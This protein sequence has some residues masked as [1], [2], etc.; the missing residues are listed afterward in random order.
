M[1]CSTSP[2][3]E[4]CR[5]G[6]STNSSTKVR[7]RVTAPN[8]GMRTTASSMSVAAQPGILGIRAFKIASRQPMAKLSARKHPPAA[9]GKLEV[10]AGCAEDRGEYNGAQKNGDSLPI[11]FFQHG[12]PKK[13]KLLL[14]TKGPQVVY[15]PRPGQI[16]IHQVQKH[17]GNVIP[18]KFASINCEYNKHKNRCGGQDAVGTA[19]VELTQIDG[20]GLRVFIEQEGSYEIARDDEEDQYAGVGV[21]VEELGR[22]AGMGEVTKADHGDGNRAEAVE[23]GNAFHDSSLASLHG[24]GLYLLAWRA[25]YNQTF[26]PRG[27]ACG[28]ST[29]TAFA[30]GFWRRS[31][32]C[33]QRRL[34]GTLQP[35]GFRRRRGNRSYTPS[36]KNWFT[37]TR[38]FRWGGRD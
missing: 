2:A 32:S 20:G 33:L 9:T 16:E 24:N 25:V 23:G 28:P 5:I 21:R 35:P 38:V 6:P 10:I 19:Y 30:V 37:S 31:L 7:A 13:I 1:T 17:G 27:A 29:V 3:I 18:S 15:H 12:W 34:P 36:R 22:R 14:D 11:P 4:Q 26:G 8:L